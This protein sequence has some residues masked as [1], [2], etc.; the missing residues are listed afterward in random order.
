MGSGNA[1]RSQP[2]P[3]RPRTG[4]VPDPGTA[5]V[6]GARAPHSDRHQHSGC[7]RAA[8]HPWG[9]SGTGL[10]WHRALELHLL[11]LTPW[12]RMGCRGTALAAGSPT[13]RAPA[14][15]QPLLPPWAIPSLSLTV[16]HSNCQGRDTRSWGRAPRLST[17]PGTT[18][19]LVPARSLGARDAACGHSPGSPT[20]PRHLRAEQSPAA[21]QPPKGSTDS[22][23]HASLLTTSPPSSPG[24]EAGGC[25]RQGEVESGEGGRAGVIAAGSNSLKQKVQSFHQAKFGARVPPSVL[26]GARPG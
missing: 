20:A 13:R 6:R 19:P 21:A 22:Q 16:T 26:R 12:A 11:Y 8:Q 10:G 17:A 3:S 7:P 15:G 4:E 18:W 1:T 23:D 5:V 9:T 24:K 25:W 14:S 2:R